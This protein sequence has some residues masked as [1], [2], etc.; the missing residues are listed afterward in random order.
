MLVQAREIAGV[1][2]AVAVDLG[3]RRLW[4]LVVPAHHRVPAA[5]E[6][7]L[8][9]ARDVATALRVDDAHLDVGQR[10]PDRRGAQLERILGARL[11][12]DGGRLGLPV[13]DGDLARVHAADDRA[14]HVGRA[15]AASDDAGAQRGEVELGKP[16]LREQGAE[17][18]RHAVQRRAALR[19]DRGERRLRVETLCGDDQRRAALQR[20]ERPE[21]GA[22]RQVQR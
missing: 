1:Q 8:R 19:R 16:S 5:P 22:E 7:A 9:A 11:G 2:P 17:H 3:G 18:P 14:H 13:R 4:Q 6:L 12:D 10:P 15:G 21:H 20:G